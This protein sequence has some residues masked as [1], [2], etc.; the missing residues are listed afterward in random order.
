MKNER[1]KYIINKISWN[2]LTKKL[3]WKAKN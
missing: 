2:K 1:M 3:L